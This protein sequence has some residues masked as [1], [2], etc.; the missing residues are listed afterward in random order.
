MILEITHLG[1]DGAGRAQGPDGAELRVARTAPGDRVEARPDGPGWAAVEAVLAP[2]PDRVA[3][4]CPHFDRGCGGCH[5]QHLAPAAQRAHKRRVVAGILGVEAP[6]LVLR[7]FQPPAGRL[8]DRQRGRMQADDGRLGFH[9]RASRALLEVDDCPLFGAELARA[10]AEVR[11]ALPRATAGVEVFA[12]ADGTY[13]VR[14]DPRTAKVAGLPRLGARWV[15]EAGLW[16]QPGAFA[17][18]DRTGVRLLVR[19]VLEA[20]A[21]AAGPVLELGAGIGTLTLPLAGRFGAVTAVELPGP[22]FDAG[23][24]NAAGHPGIRHRHAPVGGHPLVVADPPR[25]GFGGRLAP[26]LP[27]ARD[28]V[29]VACGYRGLATDAAVLREAGFELRAGWVLDLFPGSAHAEVVT[30]WTWSPAPRSRGCRS[31]AGSPR[32]RSR[33]DRDAGP[34]AGAGRRR[35]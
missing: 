32:R 10:V 29:H 9:R 18:A 21:G 8:A 27:G 13:D 17:Q 22:G 7:H 6:W 25:G 30:R 26:A 35:S 33:S 23:V 1:A 11:A 12:A 20:T 3:A 31:P 24:R 28:V 4:P 19:T 16:H 2:G 15:R 34:P 5:L 14:F